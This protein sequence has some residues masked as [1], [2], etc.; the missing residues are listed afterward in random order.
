MNIN[1]LMKAAYAD[2]ASDL[3]LVPGKPASVYIHGR[4]RLFNDTELLH[5]EL[6]DMLNSFMNAQQKR[7]L[8][9]FGDVDFSHSIP[10]LGRAR[11]NVHKQ[12]GSLA[13]AIRFINSEI[14]SFT[15]LNLPDKLSELARLPRGMILV[16]GSTGSGKSTTLATMIEYMNEHFEKHII[17]LEDPI[18]YLF[19]HKRCIIEQRE[20]GEDSP[21]FVS[22]LRHVVR[23]KPD[24]ILVGEM[25]DRETINTALTAAE[26][27]HLVLGTLHTNSAA[28]TVERVIDVFES[29]HQSQIR[30]Q[31]ATTLRAVICQTLLPRCDQPG[32]IPATEMMIVTP[33]IRH[34]IREAETHLIP[35]MIETGRKYG[36]ITMDQ[37]LAELVGAEKIS[38]ETAVS[39]AADPERLERLIN[40]YSA[41]SMNDSAD[42]DVTELDAVTTRVAAVTSTKPWH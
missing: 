35:G 34:A 16:T 21:S 41:E 15:E 12:R 36:M 38:F 20:I 27:G 4:L 1:E 18:E 5:T 14:P 28:E 22:A 17:T 37:K 19:T 2:Q 7:R 6:A 13:A 31:L 8:E 32:M 30:I 23:Q 39:K 24:V 25:R 11:V 33:A 26:T 9:E 29:S 10:G 40:N 42:N 3:I